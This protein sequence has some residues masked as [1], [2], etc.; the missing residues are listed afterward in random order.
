MM[1]KYFLPLIFIF[2]VYSE[3]GEVEFQ[4]LIKIDSNHYEVNFVLE[5]TALILSESSNDPFEILVTIKDSTVVNDFSSIQNYPIKSVEAYQDQNDVK[6]KI[7]LYEAARWAKPQQI[8]ENSNLRLFV[9]LFFG[10]DIKTMQRE[11]IVAIDAGHGGR[12]PGAI[13]SELNVI[14]KDITFLIASELARTLQNT[15]GYV[16][17]LI[18]ESDEFIYLDQRYQKS[19]RAGADIFISIHADAF[20]LPSVSGASVYVWAD[21]PSSISAK[22]LSKKVSPVRLEKYDLNEDTAMLKYPEMYA[23]KNRLSL[24]LAKKI[25]HQLKLDPNTKLHKKSVE[26]ADFRVLKSVDIPSIFLESGFISN[27]MDAKRLKG[28][29]GRRMLARSLFLGINQ[30]FAEVQDKNLFIFNKDNNLTYLIRSGDTLSEI[31][32]RFGVPV[33]DI[34]NLNMIRDEAIF[35]GQKIQIPHHQFY[36]IKP[37]DTLSEIALEYNSSL[38]EIQSLNNL[39]NTQIIVGQMIKLPSN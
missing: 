26:F 27:P 8:V 29:P 38:E 37:G 11:V 34:I 20:A 13:S 39:V 2:F 18:R 3:T 33:M 15:E 31:A 10:K 14:E 19:R 30:Y 32:I 4:D 1:K 17:V 28:K 7:S 35:P 12:D 16:P 21:N 5:N 23:E 36:E 6:I 24:S 25:L 9:P 22:N